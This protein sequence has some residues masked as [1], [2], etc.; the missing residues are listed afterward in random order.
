L[1]SNTVAQ[2][3]DSKAITITPSYPY[4]PNI[5]AY[6]EEIILPSIE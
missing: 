1:T 2:S 5:N 6:A 4:A 3:C